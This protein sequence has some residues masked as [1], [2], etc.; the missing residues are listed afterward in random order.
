MISLA[1]SGFLCCYDKIE[2]SRGHDL[3]LRTAANCA[4]KH[5][6][7]SRPH[8]LKARQL[9]PQLG[10]REQDAQDISTLNRKLK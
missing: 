4:P 7:M 8:P 10:R 2:Y 1:E 3:Y 9:R 5:V 6:G